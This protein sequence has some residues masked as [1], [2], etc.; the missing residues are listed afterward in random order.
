MPV[1]INGYALSNDG[2]LKFG[3][4]TTKIDSSGRMFVQNLPA[5]FGSRT[6]TGIARGYPWPFNSAAVNVNTAYS[7]S[8]YVFTC[9]VAGLYFTSYS[10]ITQGTNNTTNAAATS[11]GYIALVKNGVS[12]TFSHWNTNDYWDCVNLES[13]L[14]CAAGDTISYAVHISP[15]PDNGSGAGAYGDNHNMVSI[16]LIG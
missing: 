15:A 14:S 13:I 4:S 16:W 9:P 12:Q 8:T 6:G 11:S 3:S 5:F 10:V 1:D 7:T 2:G